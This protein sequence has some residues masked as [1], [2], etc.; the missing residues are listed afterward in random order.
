MS[1]I[2]QVLARESTQI[3]RKF[4]KNVTSFTG[5]PTANDNFSD[6]DLATQCEDDCITKV[7]DCIAGCAADATC[8]QEKFLNLLL[9]LIGQQIRDRSPFSLSRKYF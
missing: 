6:I 2:L 8:T 9:N 3:A 5:F 7:A 4:D 1:L